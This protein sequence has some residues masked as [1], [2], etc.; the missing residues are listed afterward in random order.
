M[1]KKLFLSA[2]TAE[3]V[4]NNNPQVMT[5]TCSMSSIDR[6]GDDVDEVENP[7]FEETQQLFNFDEPLDYPD[8]QPMDF[9]E[10]V[11]RALQEVKGLKEDN[12]ISQDS[13]QSQ[14]QALVK[15]KTDDLACC[16]PQADTADGPRI[17]VLSQQCGNSS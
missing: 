17:D 13:G 5:S 14:P 11:R 8:T 10:P 6:K 15:T 16:P 7:N 4:M 2:V 3:K 1:A 12:G 9:S